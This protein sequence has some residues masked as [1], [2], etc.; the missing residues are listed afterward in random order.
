[1]RYGLKLSFEIETI[2]PILFVE[3]VKLVDCFESVK[4]DFNNFGALEGERYLL[5]LQWS[6]PHYLSST[7]IKVGM[8]ISSLST[9]VSSL[10][11]SCSSSFNSSMIMLSL[12]SD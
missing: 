9:R 2:R 11:Y 1:M 12:A 10:L 4:L 5:V 3:R 7:W 8:F 6:R